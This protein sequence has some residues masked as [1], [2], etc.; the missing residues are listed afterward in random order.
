MWWFPNLSGNAPFLTSPSNPDHLPHP[1]LSR[2]FASSPRLELQAPR[3]QIGD[4]EQRSAHHPREPADRTSHPAENGEWAIN[5][6]PG[7]IRRHDGGSADGPGDTE[8]IYTLIIR[9]KPLFYVINIIVPC[10]L[11]SGLV[12]LAYFLPAQGIESPRPQTRAPSW[13][14]GPALTRHSLQP[15]AR[16]APSP[17]TSCS[18]RPS[19]C[20]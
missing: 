20:S 7:V 18:P 11:I 3:G 14:A 8:V 12:L 6:C 10:V 9:R 4:G 17:S 1:P 16:N 15:A 5:F 2:R 13:G 19:S